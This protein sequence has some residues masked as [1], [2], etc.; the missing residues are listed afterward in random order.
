MTKISTR[1]LIVLIERFFEE[2]IQRK[3]V[4]TMA[5]DL[6]IR[7]A[8]PFTRFPFWADDEDFVPT[9]TPSDLAISEDDKKVYVEAAVPGIN[10][11][12]IE[13]T[14]DKGIVWIKG[15]TKEEESKKKYYRKATSSFSYRVAVPGEIDHT[16]EPE[17]TCKNGVMTVAF[18][19]AEKAQPKKIAVKS[20]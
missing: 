14:F 18:T 8:F 16:T 11:S 1:A 13:V 4:T 10:P 7:N 19:K 9:T 12:D 5:G 2:L 15:E 3:E 17:A 20:A 6:T